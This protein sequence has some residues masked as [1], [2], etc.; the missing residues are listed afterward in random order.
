MSLFSSLESSLSATLLV[1]LIGVILG[2]AL[3]QLSSGAAARREDKRL[4]RSA[5]PPM[6]ELYFQQYRIDQVLMFFNLRL[7][8]S[9]T[10]MVNIFER[11]RVSYE[12][13]AKV[14][15]LLFG[16]FERGRQQNLD[17]PEKNKES[18]FRSLDRATQA[19]AKVDP[20]GAYRLSRLSNEFVLLLEIK[21]PQENLSSKEYMDTWTGILSSYRHDIEALRRLITRTAFTI[22]LV[23]FVRVLLLLRKEERAFSNPSSDLLESALNIVRK[24]KEPECAPQAASESE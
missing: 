19:L 4:R 1:P 13:S 17:L 10:K 8:K 16:K 15:A 7:G 18:M 14:L 12:E 6:L 20:V 9:L 2:W 11:E 5:L 21:F 24:T 3:S 23:D 22:G